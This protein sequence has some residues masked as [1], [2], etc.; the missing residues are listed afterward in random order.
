MSKRIHYVLAILSILLVSLTV[1][2]LTPV[3]G[4]NLSVDDPEN[5]VFRAYVNIDE[6]SQ[7]LSRGNFHDEIDIVKLN[8]SNQIFNLTFAGYINDW[9]SNGY[10]DTSA[11][12]ILHPDFNMT[13]YIQG[14]ITYPY[15]SILYQNFTS[16]F[17][18]YT[19]LGFHAF[20]IY[21]ID[22]ETIVFW[23]ETAGWVSDESYA[24]DIGY[25][26]D[27]SI[28]ADVPL[29]AY[30][31][32]DNVTCIAM[33]TYAEQLSMVEF[34]LYGDIAP[35]EYDLYPSEDDVIPSYNVFILVGLLFGISLIIIRKH[36]K[37]K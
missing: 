24:E 2:T 1:Q 15:Y 10:A 28:I 12:I 27:K 23:N 22:I 29:G 35:N 26:S 9:V 8:V 18:P 37:R 17:F 36:I 30:D 6:M 14:N 4:L 11:Q 20:F 5:D 3:V 31:I 16:S 13:L 7:E 21:V 34:L 25:V 32:P 19:S 33:T